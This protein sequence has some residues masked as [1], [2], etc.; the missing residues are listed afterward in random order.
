MKKT[1]YILL[2]MMLLLVGCGKSSVIKDEKCITGKMESIN[3]NT[4]EI[5]EFEFLLLDDENDEKRIDELGIDISDNP[6]WYEI[7]NESEETIELIV[8]ENTV[9]TFYDVGNLFV[10][11]TEDKLYTTKNFE[12]FKEF[13]EIKVPSELHPNAT[14]IGTLF[15]FVLDGDRIVSMTE[16]WVN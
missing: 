11:E 10:E 13:A 9:F 8:D 12:E 5:D 3:E 1:L 4:I 2:A 6:N 14:V 15:E 7:Y 16:I